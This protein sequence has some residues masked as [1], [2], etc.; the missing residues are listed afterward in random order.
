MDFN[1]NVNF[2]KGKLVCS[3]D[4]DFSKSQAIFL[5]DKCTHLVYSLMSRYQLLT[6]NAYLSTKNQK[7]ERAKHKNGHMHLNTD[8]RDGLS[9]SPFP[10]FLRSV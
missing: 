3:K 1:T 7:D 9:S 2:K 8:P 4:S 5:H 10:L 6:P